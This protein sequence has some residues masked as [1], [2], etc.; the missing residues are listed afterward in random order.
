MT[1]TINFI[2]EKILPKIW[3][4]I[5]NNEFIAWGLVL[6]IVSSIVTIYKNTKA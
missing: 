3:E 1:N 6:F 4:L 2:F 5:L